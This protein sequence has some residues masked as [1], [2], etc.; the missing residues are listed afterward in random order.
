[1][2]ELKP[3][4]CIH[5]HF[6]QP[7]REN[8]WIET[9]ELQESAYPYHD[10]NEKISA[11]CYSQ[12]SYSR[13]LSNDKKIRKV[14]NNYSYI[15]FNMGATLINWLK[16]FEPE[17]Y[18]SIIEAD[19]ISQKRYSG[20]G[21]AIAQAYNHIILPLANRKDKTS[22]IKWG[23]ADFILHFDRFP[24]GFWLPETAVDVET[25]EIIAE[26]GVKFVIL[27][28]HQAKAIRAVGQT[29]WRSVRPHEA[30]T[31]T[32]YLCPLPSGNSIHVFLYDGAISHGV[33]FGNL[34]NDGRAFAERLAQAGSY[35]S[36][37]PRLVNIA[38]DG[39]TYGHHHRFGD[40][41]LAYAIDYIQDHRIAT[42][43]I[44]GEFL[45]KYPAQYEIK[46]NENTSWSCPH[47]V[48]RWY[49]DCGCNVG[50]QPGWHQKW[51]EPLRM[52]LD[53]LRDEINRNLGADIM[54]DFKDFWWARNDYIQVIS[55][56]KPLIVE[57]FLQG[58][59]K[60]PQNIQDS[61]KKSTYI[62][63]MELQRLLML[64]YTS[65]GWFFDDI[66]SIE[67]VQILRYAIKA[68]D[69]FEKFYPIKLH[70]TFNEKIS[71]A[72]SNTA[73]KGNA[74]NIIRNEV[75][76]GKTNPLRSGIH[77]IISLF[78]YNSLEKIEKYQY[79]IKNVHFQ[80]MNRLEINLLFGNFIIYD[81]HTLESE[82]IYFVC[83]EKSRLDLQVY[84][85]IDM[86][87]EVFLSIINELKES[88]S[89]GNLKNIMEFLQS[90]FKQ[91]F[92][93]RHMFKDPMIKI[94]HLILN[95]AI[96][97]LDDTRNSIFYRNLRT[98]TYLA[99]N[100]I[101]IPRQIMSLMSA[102]FSK[103]IINIFMDEKINVK[104]LHKYLK[105]AEALK[106]QLY[107]EEIEYTASQKIYSLMAEHLQKELDTASLINIC[108]IIE[109]LDRSFLDLDIWKAQNMYFKIS[110]RHLD[111]YLEEAQLGNEEAFRWIENFKKLGTLLKIKLQ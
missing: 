101:E 109:I 75:L 68:I 32:P 2:S 46:I 30:D 41:A 31:T 89:K 63:I 59:I 44:Y 42:L 93:L 22:Q 102:V 65:C 13:I 79:E 29:D 105:R 92:S 19:K 66:S 43:T 64:M 12:N 24:E 103:R 99:Q 51:R 110:E 95:S 21:S 1:M 10:W 3:H 54:N 61:R 7:P 58:H 38:T 50:K 11:E 91:F 82:Q 15:S 76:P 47:G 62:Q 26:N 18:A 73:V 48:K 107:V 60:D 34:L 35:E 6:Y 86:P 74:L 33:S 55:K 25:L 85:A 8:P 106:V 16:K 9:I 14:M 37:Q 81:T 23:I 5:G 45:E 4:I 36:Q 96:Q 17:I 100:K 53:W 49:T 104:R 87:Q 39:E 72:L 83:F 40:M 71:L 70:D 56:R 77:F 28:P 52:T 27:A 78:Y 94:S 69:T 108:T 98:I 84:A 20:H 97:D 80:R 88:V 57:S 111:K 67:S 90:Y